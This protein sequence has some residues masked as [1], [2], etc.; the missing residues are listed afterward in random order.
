MDETLGKI[1]VLD[2]T[3]FHT[4]TNVSSTIKTV[5]DVIFGQENKDEEFSLVTLR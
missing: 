2:Q 3:S 4:S 1:D 5:Y